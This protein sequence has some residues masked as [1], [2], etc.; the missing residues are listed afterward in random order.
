MMNL[1]IIGYLKRNWKTILIIIL[2]LLVIKQCDDDSELKSQNNSLKKENNESKKKVIVYYKDIKKLESTNAK[3]KDSI[4]DLIVL[5]GKYK[6]HI[7]ISNTKTKND[8]ESVKG[9]KP[10]DI[11]K[12]YINRYKD[13]E[14]V[15]LS[16][17]GVSLSDTIA[18]KNIIEL[19]EKDGLIVELETTNKILENTDK[20]V[21]QKDSIIGNLEKQKEVFVSIVSEKDKQNENNEQQIK[22]VEKSLRKEK[23]KK[24]FW[25]IGI[26]IL[27]GETIYQNVNK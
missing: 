2:L 6:S 9:F 16:D 13:K 21:V 14:G 3:F 4:I 18:K 8:I 25:L 12:Y 27:L 11:P 24:V 5:N 19:V 10:N 7:A 15:A 23:R 22:N 20:I 26:G 1:D 17:K